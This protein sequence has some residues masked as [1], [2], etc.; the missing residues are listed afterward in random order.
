MN[1]DNSE[2]HHEFVLE[3]CQQRLCLGVTGVS[4][5][6]AAVNSGSVAQRRALSCLTDQEHEVST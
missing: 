6:V 5:S 4:S 3:L 2:V 1:M